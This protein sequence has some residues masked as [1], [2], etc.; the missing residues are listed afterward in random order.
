MREAS[1][2]IKG[3]IMSEKVCP[4]CGKPFKEKEEFCLSGTVRY[5]HKD[6][7]FVRK[8]HG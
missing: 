1:A 3:A 4:F 2:S 7:R 6:G 5:K 8:T